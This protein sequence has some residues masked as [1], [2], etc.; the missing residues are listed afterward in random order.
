MVI[1][2]KTAQKKKPRTRERDLG[3]VS[4]CRW[5]LEPRCCALVVQ[6][7]YVHCNKRTRTEPRFQSKGRGSGKGA[8]GG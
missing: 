8:R 1:S 6:E 4:A 3:S 5:Q 7:D 2:S